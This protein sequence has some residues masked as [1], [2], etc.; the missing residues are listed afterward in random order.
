MLQIT[1]FVALLT[2]D[3]RRVEQ[4]RN[5]CC[6]YVVHQRQKAEEILETKDEAEAVNCVGGARAGLTGMM[7]SRLARLLVS[8]LVKAGVMAATLGLLTTGLWGVTSLK[9]EFRPEWMLDPETEC[10]YN[11]HWQDTPSPISLFQSLTGITPTRSSFLQT[12][13]LANFTLE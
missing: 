2:I 6:C 11:R 12:E 1:W 8:P 10:E 9:M 4:R 3:E 5:A 13:S 7:F